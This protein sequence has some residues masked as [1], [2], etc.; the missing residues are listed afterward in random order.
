MVDFVGISIDE[1]KVL[2]ISEPKAMYQRWRISILLNDG[3]TIVFYN[4]DKDYLLEVRKY[5]LDKKEE[6]KKKTRKKKKSEAIISEKEYEGEWVEQAN[7]E[8]SNE[9]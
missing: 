6:N 4:N 2:E 8:P 3:S 9:E 7:T 1:S 5:I